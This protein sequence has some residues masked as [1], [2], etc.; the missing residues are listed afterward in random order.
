M[1]YVLIRQS[2]LASGEDALSTDD[3]VDRI[4]PAYGLPLLT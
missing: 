2:S 1:H 4:H 3:L